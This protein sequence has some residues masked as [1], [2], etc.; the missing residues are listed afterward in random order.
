MNITIT[1]ESPP[2]IAWAGYA[3]VEQHEAMVG[4]GQKLHLEIL[5]QRSRY[6]YDGENFTPI[7]ASSESIESI[8]PEQ[9]LISQSRQ[10]RRQGFLLPEHIS[11]SSREGLK[12]LID[13]AADRASLRF[14]SPGMLTVEQYNRALKQAR[15]FIDNPTEQAPPMVATSAFYEGMTEIVAAQNIID[16]AAQWDSVIDTVYDLR[17]RGKKAVNDALQAEIETT[18]QGYIDQLDAIKPA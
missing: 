2:S 5:K 3:P 7:S 11:A 18:A 4:E 8:T 14:V 6:T 13:L 17:L 1:N 9:A 10:M 16:I 12:L 15:W